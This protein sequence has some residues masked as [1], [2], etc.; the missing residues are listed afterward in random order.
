MIWLLNRR[1]LNYEVSGDAS[2]DHVVASPSRNQ[3]VGAS[4][5][6]AVS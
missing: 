6:E 3:Q 1:P 5:V 2:P 4:R